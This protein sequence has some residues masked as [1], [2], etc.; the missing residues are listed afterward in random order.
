MLD[1]QTSSMPICS[2]SITN[3][4]LKQ[5]LKVQ[6]TVY[7]SRQGGNTAVQQAGQLFGW[8]AVVYL[9]CFTIRAAG[10]LAGSLKTTNHS[11]E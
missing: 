3:N 7:M 10:S 1:R 11:P 5:Q 9:H 6:S 4:C 8:S 2:T